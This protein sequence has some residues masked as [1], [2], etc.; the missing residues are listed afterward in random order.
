[1]FKRNTE[2]VG[3]NKVIDI[4]TKELEN[5]T[6]GSPDYIQIMDQLERLYKMKASVHT[7][8]DHVSWDNLISNFGSL[9]GILL[10]LK[11]EQVNALTS[12]ALGFI[13]RV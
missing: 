13:K 2:N 9:T 10:I 1:M 7:A 6:I 5:H 12:K 4:A 11:F 8:P 3:I